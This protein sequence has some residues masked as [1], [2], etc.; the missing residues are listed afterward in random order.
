[1]KQLPSGAFEARVAGMPCWCVVTDY[2]EETFEYALYDRKGYRANWL[3]DKVRPTD[4]D[5]LLWAYQSLL[6][7]KWEQ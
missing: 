1:M 4:E 2:D 3:Q 7:S 6:D 5:E